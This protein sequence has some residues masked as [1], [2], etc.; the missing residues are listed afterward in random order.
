MGI[1][2]CVDCGHGYNTAGKRSAPFVKTV[3]HEYDGK[4]VLVRKGQCFREHEANVGVGVEL[5]KAL[6]RY[7]FDVIKSGWNDGNAKDDYC[8]A[9]PSADVSS[10]QVAISKHNVN[11]C[12]SIHFNAIGDGKSF[13]SACGLSTYIGDKHSRRMDSHYLAD[14]VQS[15]LLRCYGQKNRGIV[16]N[17]TLGMTNSTGLN[18]NASVLVELAFMTNQFEA[19]NYFCNPEAWHNY[20]VAI[21]RSLFQYFTENTKPMIIT[22]TS[23]KKDVLFVQMLLNAAIT[24]GVIECDKLVLDGDY[25]AK[26]TEAYR[27]FTIARR[28]KGC[29]GKYV[30]NNG[31]KVLKTYM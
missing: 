24:D 9:S 18:T 31:V 7:G 3:L 8:V 2:V 30:G 19:E 10:R 5:E 4:E 22:P 23:K 15:N 25:G 6:K 11:A 14:F 17:D 21:A 1:K 13:N 29:S 28:W 26:T 12:V 20:G 27:L 16:K